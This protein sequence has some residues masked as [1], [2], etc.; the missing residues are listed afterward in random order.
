MLS[1]LEVANTYRYAFAYMYKRW[2]GIS[3]L[4]LLVHKPISEN[5][6]TYLHKIIEFEKFISTGGVV[7]AHWG[8]HACADFLTTTISKPGKR[9]CTLPWQHISDHRL[10]WFKQLQFLFMSKHV[11]DEPPSAVPLAWSVLGG[12]LHPSPWI[13]LGIATCTDGAL[14]G[15]SEGT[16]WLPYIASPIRLGDFSS[17]IVK[18]SISPGTFQGAAYLGSYLK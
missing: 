17:V 5:Q 4:Y 6:W 3:I 1:I 14:P 12:S 2:K 13:I 7:W 18:P 8:L 10:V 15:L 9:R 16:A 11:L